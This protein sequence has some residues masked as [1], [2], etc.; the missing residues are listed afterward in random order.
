M[1]AGG[2]LIIL[3]GLLLIK[4]KPAVPTDVD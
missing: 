1:I 3:A 2:A 4:K